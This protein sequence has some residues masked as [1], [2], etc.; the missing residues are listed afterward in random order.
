ME[1]TS[2]RR[3]RE[4][5]ACGYRFTT[6]ERAVAVGLLVRKRDARVEPFQRSKLAAGIQLACE[7]RPISGDQIEAVVDDIED[8]L[9]S[10]PGTEIASAEIGELVCAALRGLDEVAYLRFASVYKDFRDADHFQ[11]E[12]QTLRSGRG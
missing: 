10:R 5:E 3:R 12:L 8:L 2:I 7:K 4:C 1:N 9:K 11:K 6:Y